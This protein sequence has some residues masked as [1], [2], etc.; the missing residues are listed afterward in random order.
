[1]YEK[2]AVE[3]QMI[4]MNKFI[5]D[6]IIGIDLL[7]VLDAKIDIINNKITS[8]YKGVQHSTSTVSY[9]HLDVYKRQIQPYT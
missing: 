3:C 6:G 1:M 9:T 8:N 5:Y 7:S 2:L 4:I